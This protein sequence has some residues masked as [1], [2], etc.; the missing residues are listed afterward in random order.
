M[1]TSIGTTRGSFFGD[2]RFDDRARR[3]VTGRRRAATVWIA[4]RRG[5]ILDH[6]ERR[7]RFAGERADRSAAA[8][9]AAGGTAS[10]GR[11]ARAS[12]RAPRRWTNQCESPVSDA[13][14]RQP[15]FWPETRRSAARPGRWR[16]RPSRPRTT[17]L[18]AS[19]L[20][21]PIESITSF[22]AFQLASSTSP[23]KRDRLAH[24][25]RFAE[26]IEGQ[27]AGILAH[28]PSPTPASAR[29]AARQRSARRP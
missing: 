5:G 2:E 26:L 9:A 27:A 24:R 29:P 6:A 16:H 7:H 8:A 25:H 10:A 18:S 15:P 13:Q 3:N 11:D 21:T 1:R 4:A 22:I 14:P 17:G 28:A 12:S 19:T 20:E 23:I